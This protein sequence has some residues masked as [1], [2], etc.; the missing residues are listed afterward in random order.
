[1]ET[2]CLLMAFAV[3]F[4]PCAGDEQ[5]VRVFGER[6]RGFPCQSRPGGAG[7]RVKPGQDAL[8]AQ[9]RPD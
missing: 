8:R 7:G 1:M 5:S 9:A 6:G 3:P 2:R 4:V